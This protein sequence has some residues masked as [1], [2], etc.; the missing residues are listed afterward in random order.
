MAAFGGKQGKK[1]G[2]TPTPH[3]TGTKS[4]G[5]K[6]GSA[7]KSGAGHVQPVKGAPKPAGGKTAK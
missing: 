2:I 3:K 6:T 5:G 4:P 1:I 7:T